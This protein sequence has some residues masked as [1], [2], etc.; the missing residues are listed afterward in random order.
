[1]EHNCNRFPTSWSCASARAAR[2]REPTTTPRSIKLTQGLLCDYVISVSIVVQVTT[3]TSDQKLTRDGDEVLAVLCEPDAGDELGVSEHGR[4]ALAGVVVVD[5]DGLVGA[6]GRRVDPAPVER[7]LDQRP[8]VAVRA[9]EGP[10]K[11]GT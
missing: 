2:T 5:G 1:M 3:V 9:L 10:E 7:N 4:H 8:V 11:V 6:R